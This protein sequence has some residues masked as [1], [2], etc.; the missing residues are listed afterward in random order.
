MN[1]FSWTF[2]IGF[3]LTSSILWVACSKSK[4][5]TKPEL[6]FLNTVSND[7]RQGDILGFRLNVTDKEGDLTDSIWIR[8]STRRCP[9]SVIVLPYQ[10]PEFPVKTDL[11]AEIN[12]RYRVGVIDP[13]FPI[14]NLNLCPGVD[15]TLFQFWIRDE[16]GN[17]SDTIAI[18]EPVLI[19]N[20]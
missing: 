15:T 13:G 18:P 6:K 4:F 5:N 14:W 2:Y 12:I 11:S 3:L 8:A 20:N 16:A 1:K 10:M 17:V 7:V 19:R 9:N